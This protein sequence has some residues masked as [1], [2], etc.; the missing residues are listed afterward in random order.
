M[1]VGTDLNEMPQ[2]GKGVP[3]NGQFPYKVTVTDNEYTF[4]VELSTIDGW[5]LDECA[6]NLY[7]VVHGDVLVNDNGAYYGETAFGGDNIEDGNRWYYI[8][9]TTVCCDDNREFVD[10]FARKDNDRHSFCINYN[11]DE[12]NSKITWS[13]Q[14]DFNLFEG[15]GGASHKIRLWVNVD[16]CNPW[17]DAERV[18]IGYVTVS[19]FS[20]G[21][22]DGMKLYADVKYWIKDEF[23]DEY[24]FSVV[25]VYFGLYV[26]SFDDNGNAIMPSDD[27]FY[28]EELNGVSEFTLKRLDW[29]GTNA[30]LA[31]DTYFIC[32]KRLFIT[33]S[34]FI[35]IFIM[36]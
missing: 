29:P 5:S 6:Q 15:A 31:W 9:N 14:L 22:G 33:I 19:T 18:N 12:G 17:I 24:Q 36:N 2:N 32:K 26:D 10:A 4:R 27:K 28:Q 7:M 8:N 20:E 25:N 3:T 34:F 30:N 11:D 16:Q 35:N 23:K 1:W 13:S 21:V